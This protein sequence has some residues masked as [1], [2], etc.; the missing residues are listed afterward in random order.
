M[1]G[2]SS[3]GVIALFR[4]FIS[5]YYFRNK[6]SHECTGTKRLD[7]ENCFSLLANVLSIITKMTGAKT[8]CSQDLVKVCFYNDINLFNA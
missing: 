5:N 7:F 3:N 8:H 6:L 2:P 4:I 1:P